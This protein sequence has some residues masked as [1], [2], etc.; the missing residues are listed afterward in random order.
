MNTAQERRWVFSFAMIVLILTSVPYVLGYEAQNDAWV[1]SGFVFGVEDGN[2]YIAK[3]LNGAAGDWLFRTPYTAY[4]QQGM[5]VY[6]PYLLLGKMVGGAAKHEQMLA[7]YQ[8]FRWLG[9]F[10][11]IFA[12]YDFLAIYVNDVRLRR[13]GTVL[14]TI[15]GGLGWLSVLGLQGLWHNGLALEFYSPETF[16]FL[17]LYGLPHLAVGRAMLLW[18]LRGYL[19]ASDSL[20]PWRDGLKNGLFWVVLGLMQPMTVLIGWGVIGLH[21]LIVA[22][23]WRWGKREL[24]DWA[25]WR[26]A[27]IV[28]IGMGVVSAP[29]VLYTMVALQ[30]D[31]QMRSWHSQNLILSP[32]LLDYVLAFG[33]VFPLA[34]AGGRQLVRSRSWNGWLIVG[35]VCVFP[36]LAYAPY[37]LQRRL[38]EGVWVAWVALLLVGLMHLS[39]RWQE[40]L[41]RFVYLPTVLSAII[42]VAGGAMLA[43]QR[44]PQVFRPRAEVQAYDFLAQNAQHGDVVLASFQVANY[45]A[46]WAPVRVVIGHGPESTNLR[47]LSE[48]VDRFYSADGTDQ[49]RLALLDE[50]S[51]KYVF[52]GPG[53]RACPLQVD[54][55]TWQFWDPAAVNYLQ[56]VY[57]NGDYQVFAVRQ[58]Q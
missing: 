42:L 2:S 29:L 46:A 24:P 48:R 44:S 27:V 41:L 21:G 18:G 51:V 54:C 53:E 6:M 30:V 20:H 35:W 16:G 33:L 55:A 14:V 37:N 11:Y 3:M 52:W 7:L 57:S 58:E 26:R 45:L 9:G 28:A 22:V 25:H 10:L 4:P 32:P 49:E 34:F 40:R 12:T 39:Q 13:W 1:F 19:L 47:E 50:F 36:F 8:L 43:S 56:L 23:V 5:V 17:Q 31:P 15:G 38:P